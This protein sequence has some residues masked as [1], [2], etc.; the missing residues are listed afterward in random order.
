M[1]IPILSRWTELVGK[2]KT[3]MIAIETTNNKRTNDIVVSYNK[4]PY[5]LLHLILNLRSVWLIVTKQHFAGDIKTP[6]TSLLVRLSVH[7]VLLELSHDQFLEDFYEII[8]FYKY[9]IFGKLHYKRSHVMNSWKYYL[10]EKSI[11]I[12]FNACVFIKH[13]LFLVIDL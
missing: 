5:R 8:I 13:F 7:G 1:S 11:K 6:G 10:L 12:C 3:G 4:S 9:W 2:S